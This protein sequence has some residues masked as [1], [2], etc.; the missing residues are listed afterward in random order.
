[1]FMLD[2]VGRV[3]TLRLSKVNSVILDKAPAAVRADPPAA[4]AAA[5]ARLVEK[6]IINGECVL[7]RSDKEVRNNI[8][9]MI[10]R[11]FKCISKLNF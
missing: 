3:F 2:S 1:M 7:K 4:E 6:A 8:K 9:F 11:A 5:A 10:A